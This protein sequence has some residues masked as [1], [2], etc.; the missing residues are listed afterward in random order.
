MDQQLYTKTFWMNMLGEIKLRKNQETKRT[1]LL[2]RWLLLP[3]KG[4]QQWVDLLKNLIKKKTL[5]SPL[6]SRT[7]SNGLGSL[8][9]MMR[10]TSL[11]VWKKSWRTERKTTKSQ[12]TRIPTKT[13]GRSLT[14]KCRPKKK[15][16]RSR[17][18]AKYLSNYTGWLTSKFASN[19]ADWQATQCSFAKSSELWETKHWITL[20]MLN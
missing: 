3:V 5:F 19:S 16:K 18:T 14:K 17:R 15:R 20:T 11:S 7:P 8:V 10:I 6:S 4:E 13:S 9:L 12:V 1:N 2:R